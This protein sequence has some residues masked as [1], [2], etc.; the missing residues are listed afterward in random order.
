MVVTFCGHSRLDNQ[1]CI[2]KK[3]DEVIE[4]LINEGANEFLLGGR[5]EFDG[6]CAIAVKN[7]KT[8]HP[9]IKSFYV[10]TRMNE[11]YIKHLYDSSIYPD[12]ESVPG[13]IAILKRNEEMV[14]MSDVLVSH[15]THT[16]GGAY[17]T[18]SFAKRKKKRIMEVYKSSDR[19]TQSLPLFLYKSSI[20][21]SQ[22]PRI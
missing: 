14:K 19:E 21:P 13:K 16:F 2:S 7:A 22:Y 20:F 6:L 5:G 10:Q 18:Y 9:N 17:K 1:A 8:N 4:Q 3:L 15:I 12:I 11:N